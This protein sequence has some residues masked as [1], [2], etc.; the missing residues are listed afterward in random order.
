MVTQKSDNFIIPWQMLGK[1]MLQ[2]TPVYKSNDAF[3]KHVKSKKQQTVQSPSNTFKY[4]IKTAFP[5]LPTSI[6]YLIFT[7]MQLPIIV[8]NI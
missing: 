6:T 2:F 5:A 7:I 8:Y 4:L 3:I 1:Y